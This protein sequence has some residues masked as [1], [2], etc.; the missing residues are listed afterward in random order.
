MGSVEE[1]EAAIAELN[2]IVS[3]SLSLSL[4]GLAASC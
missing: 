4:E 3:V 1:A 2:G